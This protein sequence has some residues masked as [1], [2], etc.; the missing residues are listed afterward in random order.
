[1]K[2]KSNYLLALTGF[3]TIASAPFDVS[4]VGAGDA[5]V[6]DRRIEEG[7]KKMM[8]GYTLKQAHDL[9]QEIIEI[10]ELVGGFVELSEKG[11]VADYKKF[12]EKFKGQIDRAAKLLK[13]YSILTL[14]VTEDITPQFAS[15]LENNNF[16]RLQEAVDQFILA[17][18]K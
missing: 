5:R 2:I 6:I 12:N 17:H 1:M 8:S 10:N 4:A 9:R 14:D 18:K 15:L 16:L 7:Y 11:H 13:K 3:M